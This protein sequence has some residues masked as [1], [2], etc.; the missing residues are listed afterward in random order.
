MPIS[1]VAL[2]AANPLLDPHETCGCESP[3]GCPGRCSA[4]SLCVGYCE[5]NTIVFC[6]A[7]GETSLGCIFDDDG[8]CFTV[9]ERRSSDDPGKRARDSIKRVQYKYEGAQVRS[10]DKK[11][12]GAATESASARQGEWRWGMKSAWST[13]GVDRRVVLF[14]SLLRSWVEEA[15]KY[16]RWS[17][18]HIFVVD[19]GEELTWR[20]LLPAIHESHVTLSAGLWHLQVDGGLRREVVLPYFSP[21]AKCYLRKRSQIRCRQT[22][23]EGSPPEIFEVF[24]LIDVKEEGDF[25]DVWRGYGAKDLKQLFHAEDRGPAISASNDVCDT[26]G[27]QLSVV[28]QID[29]KIVQILAHM[30]EELADGFRVLDSDAGIDEIRTHDTFRIRHMHRD[31]RHIGQK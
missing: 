30:P 27:V 8:T 31:P 17:E 10:R 20:N 2:V 12:A 29:A 22:V 19:N 4:N 1:A 15:L 26:K 23:V 3:T 24:N 6:G 9:P 5:T 18:V 21:N 16:E 25:R 13:H 11:A 28:S 7:C 14:E